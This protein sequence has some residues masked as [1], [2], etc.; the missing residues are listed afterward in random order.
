VSLP[1]IEGHVLQQL[2]LFMNGQNPIGT[3]RISNYLM[4]HSRFMLA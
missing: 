4:K 3:F 2:H 1:F